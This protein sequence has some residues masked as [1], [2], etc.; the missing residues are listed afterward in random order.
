MSTFGRF[1]K[2]NERK[3]QIFRSR[4][5]PL[6]SQAESSKDDSEDEFAVPDDNSVGSLPINFRQR[7]GKLTSLVEVMAQ[8]V[9]EYMGRGG[10][11]LVADDDEPH[12]LSPE[13]YWQV[14]PEDG[15]IFP[16]LL[17]Q[18]SLAEELSS[19]SKVRKPKVLFSGDSVPLMEGAVSWHSTNIEEL[20]LEDQITK[21]RSKGSG[22]LRTAVTYIKGMVG[23]YILYLPHLFSLGGYLSSSI[24]LILLAAFSIYAMLLLLDCRSR[25]VHSYGDI[26]Y[27]SY[28]KLGRFMVDF[29][30]F[31]SQLAF[32]ATYFIF[33]ARNMGAL[34]HLTPLQAIAA[35][36]L[37]YA[38]LACVRRL[39]YLGAGMLLA[40]VCLLL[41]LVLTLYRIIAELKE[42][43]PK[44]EVIAVNPGRSIMVIGS[45]LS[46][47]EGT[48][49]V[50][51]IQ[52]AM[53]PA[54]RPNFGSILITC[55]SAVAILFMLFGLLGYLAYGPEVE[56]FI[57][58]ELPIHSVEGVLVRALYSIGIVFTFP[59][60]LFPAVKIVERL[61][62]TPLENAK[63]P[64]N[65]RRWGKN[66]L[67]V[68]ICMFVASIALIGGQGF[69]V[70]VALVG[71][72]CSVPLSL[73]YPVVF[74]LQLRGKFISPTAK[75]IEIGLAALGILGAIA[76]VG[77]TIANL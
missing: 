69:D 49:L 74:H 65:R 19:P 52:D 43:G 47:F 77:T 46:A 35:Q 4:S 62:W 29:S 55:T 63:P 10:G 20:Y 24:I 14:S 36:L 51:P 15:S 53:L 54:L 73:V 38:P 12:V 48:G 26:G 57:T 39:Q 45:V 7:R 59:L 31:V 25:T 70:F 28:N 21:E 32:C 56:D 30:L 18:T 64:T 1:V 66:L 27:A 34:L 50:L 8:D 75:K 33:I 68:A 42:H 37:I 11:T 71:A 41:G 72:F 67:R 9:Q 17:S 44:P 2:K 23:T 61:L 3:G 76:A 60:Q 13:D 6:N 58:V 16:Q 40:N 22:T 5:M